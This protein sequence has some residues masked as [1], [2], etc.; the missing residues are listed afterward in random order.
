MFPLDFKLFGAIEARRGGKTITDFRS[1]K[2]LVLLAYLI[3]EDRPVTR[4]FLAGLA[5]PDATQSQ[6]LGLLRRTLHDLN[7]RLSGCLEMDRRTVR[8][9]PTAT[10]TVDIHQFTALIAQDEISA[11]E[12]AV[13]LYRA[14]FLHGIYVDDAPELETWLLQE[15]E[16]WR[17][18]IIQVLN[19]LVEHYTQQAAYAQA[20]GFARRLLA[21]E[22]WRE[23][24]HRQT[25]LL[26]AREQSSRQCNVQ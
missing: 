13:A 1:Q 20:L 15:Q 9:R 21:L 17:Q 25:M 6:A 8:F 3:C 26:L 18:A 14:S 5:W 4:D 2:A 12:E 10:T 22:P 7:Q 24:T 23:E 19:R 11:R 16:R